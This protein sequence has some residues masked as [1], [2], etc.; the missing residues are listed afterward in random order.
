MAISLV[1]FAPGTQI[2][3]HTHETSAEFMWIKTG[4]G[5]LEVGSE[6]IQVGAEHAIH[7]P[8]GQPHGGRFGTAKTIGVQIYAPAGP[9]QRFKATAK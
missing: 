1:E 8:R 7:I 4:G 2:A 3:Q 5:T 6:K 9:E